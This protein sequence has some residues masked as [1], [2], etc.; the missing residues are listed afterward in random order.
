MYNEQANE[1]KVDRML[2]GTSRVREPRLSK[3]GRAAEVVVAPAEKL[4][5]DEVQ[6]V[7]GA[8]NVMGTCS[9]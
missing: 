7:V 9:G 6:K 3:A 1:R 4:L 2:Q 8:R 5:R